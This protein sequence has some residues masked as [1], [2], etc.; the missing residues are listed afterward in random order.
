MSEPFDTLGTLRKLGLSVG[1]SDLSRYRLAISGKVCH[2]QRFSLSSI[3]FI[4][5]SSRN[6]IRIILA[7]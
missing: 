2:V 1:T 6:E 7:T 5:V 3:L 4:S